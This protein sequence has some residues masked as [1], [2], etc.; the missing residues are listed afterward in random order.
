MRRALGVCG[1]VILGW[2]VILKAA[3]YTVIAGGGGT[4]TTIQAC[5]NA[6]VAGDTCE[7]YA[8]TYVENVTSVRAGTNDAT[9]ITIR[10]HTGDTPAVTSFALTHNYITISGF[11]V[12]TG[13]GGQPGIQATSTVGTIVENTTI[14]AERD[15]CIS[16]G[17]S[18]ATVS[19]DAILRNNTITRCGFITFDASI[20]AFGSGTL[21]EGND[22][23]HGGNDPIQANGTGS[24]IRNNTIH[25]FDQAETGTTAHIDMIHN[26]SLGM[27]GFLIEG[28]VWRDCDDPTGNCHA[29]ILQGTHGSSDALDNVIARFNHFQRMDNTGG[30]YVGG[31]SYSPYYTVIYNNTHTDTAGSSDSGIDTGAS[32]ISPRVKNNIFYNIASNS[33]YF[34]YHQPIYN[35]GSS[36]FQSNGNLP[37]H[38]GYFGAWT[39]AI[40]SEATYPTLRNLDPLFVSAIADVHLQAASPARN[41][42]VALTT[43]AVA[44]TSA[45]TSLVL[46]DASY[47]A[48]PWGPS[49]APT[50]GDVIRIGASTTAQVCSIN[51]A[52]NTVTLCSGVSRNDGDN[53]YLYK[54]SDGVQ[55]LFSA[56]P[57]LGAYPYGTPTFY[58][59]RF[60]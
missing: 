23:S 31:G 6:A 2:M 22:I 45:G 56:N 46:T 53:V 51:Y 9:R 11:T 3:T 40:A 7:V 32:A 50:Q 20:Y 1:V 8:G 24:V 30:A 35:E 27:Q 36:D 26:G 10:N 48:P 29:F 39:Q 47:F 13:T 12:N 15:A 52:T 54:K 41:A 58:R 60:R 17:T 42:G 37:F 59:L 44:D 16:L 19:T 25:N 21:I 57:D 4:Y 5:V 43:V 14:T 18:G 49:Y 28:N 33:S 55:V 34:A 38:S